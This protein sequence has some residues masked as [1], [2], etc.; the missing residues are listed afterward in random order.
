MLHSKNNLKLKL[1][2]LV[3]AH[4]VEVAS[5]YDPCEPP[6]GTSTERRKALFMNALP[7]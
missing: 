5:G 3:T 1:K 4:F 7:L 2:L 6:E